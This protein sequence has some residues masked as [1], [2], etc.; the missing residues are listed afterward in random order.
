[1]VLIQNENYYIQNTTPTNAQKLQF[2][3]CTYNKMS[4]LDV[5]IRYNLLHSTVFKRSHMMSTILLNNTLYKSVHLNVSL[6]YLC[7]YYVIHTCMNSGQL[8]YSPLFP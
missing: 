4:T 1:M 5:I 8:I 7:K 2:T 3:L 6:F